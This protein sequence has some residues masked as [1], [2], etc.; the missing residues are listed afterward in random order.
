MRPARGLVHVVRC[1]DLVLEAF[2]EVLKGVVHASAFKNEY[3][4]NNDLISKRIHL[5]FQAVGLFRCRLLLLRIGVEK[6]IHL[7]VVKL[8]VLDLHADFTF[9]INLFSLFFYLVKKFTDGPRYDTFIVTTFRIFYLWYELVFS[10]L[11][12]MVAF[13][14]ERLATTSLSIYKNCGM[15]TCENL[16]N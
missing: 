2:P 4:L 11:C 9:S 15:E 1:H 13:H 10:A 12:I 14:S 7:L 6:V 5:Q 16:L 8:D 3:V